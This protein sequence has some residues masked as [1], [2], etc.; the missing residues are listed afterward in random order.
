VA[1]SQ[2]SKSLELRALTSLA[3]LEHSHARD[4]ARRELQQVYDWFTEGFDTGDLEDARAVLAERP[5]EAW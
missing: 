4:T 3:R 5:G 1:R 2:Y